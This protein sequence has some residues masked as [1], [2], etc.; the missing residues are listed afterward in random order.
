[1]RQYLTVGWGTG[2]CITTGTR[3][4]WGENAPNSDS[5][6]RQLVLQT[7]F[8]FLHEVG[9]GFFMLYTNVGNVDNTSSENGVST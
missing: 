5:H 1:M 3:T 8:N 4:A 2:E 9:L 7:L 6:R